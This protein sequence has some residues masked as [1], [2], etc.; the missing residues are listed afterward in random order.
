MIQPTLHCYSFSSPPHPVL[1]DSTSVAAENILL[2]DTFFLVLVH[3]GQT[4]ASWRQYK[5]LPEYENVRQ[6]LQAPK[7]DAELLMTDRFPVPQF[8]E[9]D[10]HTSKA[11]FLLCRINPSTTHHNSQAGYGQSTGE[12]VYTDDASLQVF[13]DHLK[14]LAVSS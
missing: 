1:L 3:T 9:C 7:S 12:I 14:N 8:I 10:Q 2:L 11:R 5:D 4:V 6:L 13:M